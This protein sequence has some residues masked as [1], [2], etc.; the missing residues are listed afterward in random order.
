MERIELE[1]L[2]AR[3]CEKLLQL[4]PDGM[5]HVGVYLDRGD[6]HEE[7]DALLCELLMALGYVHVVELYHAIGKWY[8]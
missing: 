5:A 4:D 1:A 7:A 6:A 3:I 2:V 8:N